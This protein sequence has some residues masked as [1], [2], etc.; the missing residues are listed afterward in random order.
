L[1][2]KRLVTISLIDAGHGSAAGLSEMI[3]YHNDRRDD[4]N[5]DGELRDRGAPDA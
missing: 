5:G 3:A 1:L 2:E 4:M